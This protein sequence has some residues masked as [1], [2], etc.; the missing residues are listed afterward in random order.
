MEQLEDALL[1]IRAHS[2][3]ACLYS[4]CDSLQPFER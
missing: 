1:I 2:L 3:K 4:G